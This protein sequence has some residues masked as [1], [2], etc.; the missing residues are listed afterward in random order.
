MTEIA[1]SFF[2]GFMIGLV[3]RPKDKDLQEQQEIYDNKLFE[4]RKD[5]EYYKDLCKWHVEQRKQNDKT[6]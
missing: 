2:I 3:M 5:V 6:I 4:Y 1:L